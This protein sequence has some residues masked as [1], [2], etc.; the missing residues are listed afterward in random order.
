MGKRPSDIFASGTKPLSRAPLLM[1]GA[2]FLAENILQDTL[3]WTP[4]RK[5]R[6][7]EV[8]PHKGSKEEPVLGM[9]SG[10]DKAYK[11]KYTCNQP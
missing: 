8:Q 3:H 2:V 7:Q 4:V 6:L 11:D 9:N 10:E 5:P 1:R